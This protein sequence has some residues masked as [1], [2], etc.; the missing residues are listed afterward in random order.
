MYTS[1]DGASWITEPVDSEGRVG[2]HCTIAIDSDDLPHIA[3]VDRDN[4]G[5]IKYGHKTNHGL[6][7]R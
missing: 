7:L 1:F 6:F 2:E 4:G 5:V 3:Y